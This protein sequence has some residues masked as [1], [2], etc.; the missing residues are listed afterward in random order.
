MGALNPTM[1]IRR[2]MKESTGR[3]DASILNWLYRTG[4]ADPER[5]ADALPHRLSGG[6]RQRVVIAMSMMAH[7]K[8]LIAD[9]PTTALDV[10]IR[11]QILGLLRSLAREQQMA[12]LFVT[13]DL[14]VAASLADRVLVL[15]AGRITEIG[16][17]QD[18]IVNPAHPYT[19]GL[20]AA[21]FDFDSDRLRPL[22]TLPGE[23]GRSVDAESSCAYALRCPLAQADCTAIRPGP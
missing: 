14:S 12:I 23:H 21:R 17:I 11:A 5:I 6:Q 4:L 10:T 1:T 16:R 7:P 22:P 13:H 15:Y 18:V 20:L 19:S 2:Q 3:A 8:L 9:E